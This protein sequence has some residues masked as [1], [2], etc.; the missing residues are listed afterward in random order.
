MPSSTFS[1]ARARRGDL[2]AAWLAGIGESI[3]TEISRRATARG[4]VVN[5]GQ[6]FPNFEGPPEIV[7]A[8]AAA[9]RAGHNQYAPAPGIPELRAAIADW[10]RRPTASDPGG[11]PPAAG[12]SVAGWDP[13]TEITV[14]SGCTEAL[15]AT[16]LAL[17]RPGDEVVGLEPFYDAYPAVCAMAGARF[18]PVTL[19][20]PDFALD[21]DALRAAITPR[22]RV[23]LLN[24]PHNPTGRVLSE[25]DLALV[26]EL[27]LE[28]DLVAVTDEV[29]ERLVFDRPHR[30]LCDLPDMRERTVTLSSLGKTFSFTGWKIG[31]A[32]APVPLTR[33][34]R[35]VHQFLVFSSATPLQ[36][37]ATAALRLG[38][39]YFADYEAAY[40]RRRDLLVPGLQRLGFDLQPPEGTYFVLA[41]HRPLGL[42][43]D[44]A[45]VDR[46]ID[47]A[48]V[49]AIPASA[50][51]ADPARGAHLVR[52]SF[53]S[54][55]AAI[56]EA[57]ERLGRLLD[58][59]QR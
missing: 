4:D 17:L 10:M 49:A 35:T 53:C 1:D 48:G 54:T 56:A 33:L 19:P 9:L 37:A 47:E 13:E 44:R 5:L 12:P 16:L 59:P 46:L 52:F 2:G 40:R 6:G 41:D 21:P 3:F 25:D 51:H 11:A 27:C 32:V 50:F 24:T 23:I 29:Y 18:V 34:L 55:E 42:G 26:R 30:R 31:W 36:H 39:D 38:P 7:E 45:V 57:L 22:T 15:P 43:D 8:A 58:P 28:H 14:T 20:A